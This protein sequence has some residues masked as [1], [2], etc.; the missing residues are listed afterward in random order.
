MSTVESTSFKNWS[1]GTKTAVF[2]GLGVAAAVV[3]WLNF[4]S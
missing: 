4:L 3:V 2:V 1:S